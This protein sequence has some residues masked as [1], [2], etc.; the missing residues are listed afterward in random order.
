M[1]S[2]TMKRPAAALV[3]LKKAVC[4]P[5][6]KKTLLAG[7]GASGAMNIATLEKQVV[8]AE[9]LAKDAEVQAARLQERVAL[10][11]SRAET[12][13][14]ALKEQSGKLSS[15]EA[16][17]AH[18][19]GRAEIL[20][21]PAQSAADALQRAA[22]AE[23]RAR[24]LGDLQQKL[25][26]LINAVVTS[27]LYPAAHPR[28]RQAFTPGPVKLELEDGLWAAHPCRSVPDKQ[29]PVVAQHHEQDLEKS[30]QE[31]ASEKATLVQR[32]FGALSGNQRR[33]LKP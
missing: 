12:A 10:F 5:P 17:I 24:L 29:T 9:K 7:I 13:E 18:A 16:R 32:A 19:E 27:M 15:V 22:R 2:T 11:L 31:Q 14:K 21:E 25:P 3:S 6:T 4:E 26:M 8:E 1:P 20:T 30:S 33:Q 23:E 28:S